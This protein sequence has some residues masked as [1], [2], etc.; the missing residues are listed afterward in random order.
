M[1][2]NYNKVKPNLII[3]RT[4][5]TTRLRLS[6]SCRTSNDWILT[7]PF[8]D[9]AKLVRRRHAWSGVVCDFVNWSSPGEQLARV[10]CANRDMDRQIRWN[11]VDTLFAASPAFVLAAS[12]DETALVLIGPGRAIKLLR[13]LDTERSKKVFSHRWRGNYQSTKKLKKKINFQPT[14]WVN[15]VLILKWMISR[16]TYQ[17]NGLRL[18]QRNWSFTN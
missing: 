16:T 14:L 8:K 3:L 13:Y 12:K 7:D 11:A 6:L 9:H 17:K 15:W 10:G 2:T 18:L 4:K 5:I 1:R